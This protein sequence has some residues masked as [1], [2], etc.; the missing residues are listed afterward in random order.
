MLLHNATTKAYSSIDKA[1]CDCTYEELRKIDLA[2][3]FRNRNGLSLEQC[4]KHE[5]VLLE[6]A[7]D[8]ILRERKAR[9][10]LQPKSDYTPALRVR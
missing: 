6:D 10:S 3:K 4:P 9:L 2:E 8:L 1:V 5:I 7:L